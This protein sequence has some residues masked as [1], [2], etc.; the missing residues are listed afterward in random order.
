MLSLPPHED[1]RRYYIE[2]HLYLIIEKMKYVCSICGY[3][4]DDAEQKVPFA[5]LPDDWK[6]PLCGAAK[7][8]FVAQEEDSLGRRED[9]RARG[10][11]AI[12]ADDDMTRLSSGQ[13]SA[14]FSNLA[15][16]CEKQ[17]KQGE[18]ALFTQ[19][20]DY[21]NS[22]SPAVED[23]TVESIEARLRSE[24]DTYASLGATVKEEKDR[25]AQRACVWGEKVTK[26]LLSLAG[27]YMKE[28]EKFLEGTEVW[29]CTVCGFVYVGQNP[30]EI[31]PVCKVPAWK[32][33]KI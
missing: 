25:G 7:S 15:R 6:C 28:G 4:Y 9:K 32:F 19:L 20:A 13:L 5:S 24:A 33:E 3:V 27:R 10:V 30:P 18:S 26:M 2:I 16:G 29:V 1:E 17:Y 31:C 11:E 21:F 12:K 22:L 14:L 8:D 23:A